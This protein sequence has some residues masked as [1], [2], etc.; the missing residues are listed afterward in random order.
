VPSIFPDFNSLASFLWG[1]KRGAN[2]RKEK[3]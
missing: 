3:K 2:R 1:P